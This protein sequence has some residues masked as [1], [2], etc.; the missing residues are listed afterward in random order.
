MHPGVPN[1]FSSVQH[2][3]SDHLSCHVCSLKL[4]GAA[5]SS[6]P[7]QEWQQGSRWLSAGSDVCVTHTALQDVAEGEL[8]PLPGWMALARAEAFA[9]ERG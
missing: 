3:S 7:S 8:Q 6:V 1:P 4:T 9:P 2:E 5:F